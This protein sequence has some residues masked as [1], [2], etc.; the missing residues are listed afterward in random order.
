VAACN[1]DGITI[2]TL[3]GILPKNTETSRGRGAGQI[4]VIEDLNEEKLA[5]KRIVFRNLE[6]LIIDE[7]SM[8]P[9][10][11]FLAVNQRLQQIKDSSLPFGGV[12]VIAVGDYFQLPPVTPTWIFNSSSWTV[13]A[14]WRQFTPFVF[15]INERQ[16]GHVEWQ[17][18][19]NEVREGHFPKK[20]AKYLNSLKD[21]HLTDPENW[22]DA[23]HIFETNAEVKAYNLAKLNEID[24]ELIIRPSHDRLRESNGLSHAEALK[25]K[26]FILN[27]T[28]G[29][30]DMFFCK[31]GA[32]VMLTRNQKCSDKLFNGTLG[33][34]ISIPENPKQPVEIL[35]TDPTAG[36]KRDVL[37]Q[38]GRKCC[39]YNI[40][41]IHVLS[42]NRGVLYYVNA[43]LQRIYRGN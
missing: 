33:T 25:D 31:I 42:M 24:S 36:K 19:L 10:G 34:I 17:K 38:T 27:K 29:L 43:I 26:P 14:L 9:D 22:H 7:I 4:K 35:C 21:R 6:Y 13:K 32:N 28:G 15:E 16:S 3:F 11:L 1:V 23:V 40:I 37:I 2:H 12:N 39:R 41:L 8:I 18:F 30:E 20:V 5:A